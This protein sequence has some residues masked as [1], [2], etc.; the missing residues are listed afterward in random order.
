M[1]YSVDTIETEQAMDPLLLDNQL[2]YAL[3]AAAHR[4]TKSYRPLLERLGLTYPQYLVLLVLWEQDGV[5]VSEIG[6]RL[7]LDSGTLTPVLKRLESAGFLVRTR[8]QSDEREVEIALTP[9]GAALRAE[10]VTVRESVMCQLELSE[11]EIRA[12][13]KDLGTLI[14]RLSANGND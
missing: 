3:Y 9:Q 2:C 10:A 13:R 8:R 14:E 7:R 4:M 1:S 11:P 12:L 5:T 6:R